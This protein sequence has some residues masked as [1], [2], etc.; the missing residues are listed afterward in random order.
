MKLFLWSPILIIHETLRI[1][2]VE[3]AMVELS[4]Y[5]VASTGKSR[6]HRPHWG[7]VP[8]IYLHWVILTARRH[9]SRS[10]TFF[11]GIGT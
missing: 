10:T 5:C 9:W 3:L 11:I 7:R 6:P 4:T 1:R 8:M 2:R